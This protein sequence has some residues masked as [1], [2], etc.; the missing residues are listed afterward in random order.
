MGTRVLPEFKYFRPKSIDEAVSLAKKYG[1]KAKFLAGG[2]DLVV[3]MK[4]LLVEPECLIDVTAIDELKG[5]NSDEK[6]L[7]IGATTLLSEIHNLHLIKKNYI[8]LFEATSDLATTQVRNIATIGGNLCNASPGADCAPP[9]LVL[10]A[11]VDIANQS[12]IKT[13]PLEEFFIGPKKTVM[14]TGDLLTRIS[15]SAQAQDLATSFIKISRT[16]SDLA[17]LN[18]AAALRADNG[19]CKAVRIALGAVAPTPVRAKKAEDVLRNKK[20]SLDAIDEAAS[21]V[22]KDIKPITDCRSTEDYRRDVA[23]FIVKKALQKA[24]KR[25]HKS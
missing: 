8:A 1:D 24:F 12:G 10:G 2:T 22:T 5:I 25:I 6:G 3:D 21:M 9:L 11:K 19:I 7:R 23:V 17:Q 13:V 18:A 20:L 4:I 14:T 15:L 16:H